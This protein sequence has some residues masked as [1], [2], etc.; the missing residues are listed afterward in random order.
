MNG[1]KQKG[2]QYYYNV[3]I[4]FNGDYLSH[5]TLFCKGSCWSSLTYRWIKYHVL[6]LIVVLL[7]VPEILKTLHWMY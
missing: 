5:G 3:P 7:G 2:K 6:F 4:E 1:G